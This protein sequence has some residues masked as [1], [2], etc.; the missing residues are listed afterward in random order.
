MKHGISTQQW[1]A[2]SEGELTASA[3]DQLEA[4]LLGCHACWDLYTQRVQTTQ[5]LR[6]AGAAV[7]DAVPLRDGAAAQGLQTVLVRAQTETQTPLHPRIRERLA[8]LS[9]LL[10]LLCGVQMAERVL[11]VAAFGS[12]AQSLAR[13]TLG[14][15]EPFLHRL[16]ALARFVGGETGADL[17]WESGQMQ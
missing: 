11:T 10:T 5:L 7:R 12:P 14:A 2:Y 17:I 13:L 6:A 15:W 8:D 16:T 4:H 9:T 3:R 1:D